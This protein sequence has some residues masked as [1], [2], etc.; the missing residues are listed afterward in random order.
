MTIAHTLIQTFGQHASDAQADAM[1]QYMRHQ[2]SFFGIAAPARKILTTNILKPLTRHLPFDALEPE[3]R[4]LW[5]APERECQYAAIE[6]LERYRKNIPDTALPFLQWL[7]T[8]KSWW[9]TVDSIASHLVGFY[10]QQ[11][12]QQIAPTIDAW[13]ASE[14]LWL[15]RTCLIFQLRYRHQTDVAL[16]L[17]NI[18]YLKS[19]KDFFIQKAIGWS[20]RQYARE[21]PQTVLDFLAQHQDLSNLSKREATKGIQRHFK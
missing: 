21:N 11:Y 12:P 18:E 3:I 2:F 1:A 14:N 5:L 13:L 20:L 8:E 16:L 6:I 17:R 4:Q 10:F 19:H 9:D 7:I 15:Q